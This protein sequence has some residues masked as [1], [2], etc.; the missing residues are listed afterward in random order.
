M[1]RT[2]EN[3]FTDEVKN[4]LASLPITIKK[5]YNKKELETIYDNIDYDMKI[6]EERS[7]KSKTGLFELLD[8]EEQKTTKYKPVDFTFVTKTAS[9]EIIIDYLRCGRVHIYGLSSSFRSEFLGLFTS[10]IYFKSFDDTLGYIY[11]WVIIE[12]LCNK[13]LS[14]EILITP[15]EN[16]EDFTY[17]YAL[18][19]INKEAFLLTTSIEYELIIANLYSNK[20]ENKKKYNKFISDL[21]LMQY[22]WLDEKFNMGAIEAYEK[23]K[24]ELYAVCKYTNEGTYIIP[25]EKRKYN[26]KK[27]NVLTYKDNIIHYHKKFSEKEAIDIFERNSPMYITYIFM[28]NIKKQH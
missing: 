27:L 25:D 20:K 4:F 2:L 3:L 21:T 8:F 7:K 13:I 10:K 5:K 18:S 24:N 6:Y 9:K 1:E 28:S 12:N 15:V 14:D 11:E 26:L 16:D 22:A 17:M 23:R 19:F